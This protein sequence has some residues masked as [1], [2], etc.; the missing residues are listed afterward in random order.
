MQGNDW[1][2]AHAKPSEISPQLRTNTQDMKACTFLVSCMFVRMT[3]ANRVRIGAVYPYPSHILFGVSW[4]R[5]FFSLPS[6][7]GVCYFSR[8]IIS[9]LCMSCSAYHLWL[10]CT[11]RLSRGFG[12]VAG[13]LFVAYSLFPLFTIVILAEVQRNGWNKI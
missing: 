12:L 7:N 2:G 1:A 6:V 8:L 13:C 10:I 4:V 11:R 3:A 5:V 9:M